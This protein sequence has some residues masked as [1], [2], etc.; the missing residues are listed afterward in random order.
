MVTAREYGAAELVTCCR[1]WGIV[2]APVGFCGHQNA[3][4]CGE[5]ACL[6]SERSL[7]VHRSLSVRSAI[8]PTLSPCV[9]LRIM[10]RRGSGTRNA[11]KPKPAPAPTIDETS[12]PADDNPST[13]RAL[14]ALMPSSRAAD[15]LQ[16]ERPGMESPPRKK[17]KGQSA[18]GPSQPPNAALPNAAL[19]LAGQRSVAVPTPRPGSPPAPTSSR[20]Q[21]RH[22]SCSILRSCLEV[23]P[24][25]TQSQ[26]QRVVLLSPL[27]RLQR[28]LWLSA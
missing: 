14:N 28:R 27:P 6:S 7:S 18:A 21:M 10:P 12:P 20:D 26:P 2:R 5:I 19:P 22:A 24:P 1:C 23:R 15:A 13:K 25:C 9:A 11:P 16:D 4:A 8:D 3:G 17:P